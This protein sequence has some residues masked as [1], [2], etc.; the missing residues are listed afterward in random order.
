M[1][2]TPSATSS[3]DG[4]KQRRPNT[5]IEQPPIIEKQPESIEPTTAPEAVSPWHPS[6]FPDGGKDAYLCLLGAACCLFCSFGWINCLGIFQNYYQRNQLRDY[7]PSTIAWIASLEIFCMFLPGPIVGWVYDNHGPRYILIFGTL[8]HVFGLM[9]T[10]LC[11]EFWQFVLAQGICSPLGLNCIFQ[12]GTSSIPTWFLKKRGISY[13]MMAAGSGLGGIIFP[14]MASHLIPKIGYGWTMRTIAFVILGLMCI[15]GLTVKSRLP[16]RPRPFQLKVFLEPF[17]DVSFVLLTTS[18]FLF[19]FGLFIPINF[20]EVQAI[21]NGMSVR[22]AGYLLA[23]LNAASIFGRIIPG[24]LADKVGKFNMQALWCSVAGIIVLALGLPASG[25][26]A[27]ITF[28]AIYGFSSGAFVSLL[29]A[30]IAHIS[31]VEQIGLRV[32]VIFASISFAGLVGNPIAGAIVSRNNGKYW[33]L[34]VFAGIML[35]A[36]ASMFFCTRMYIAKW[37]LLVRV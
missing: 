8:M 21:A 35:L 29:P 16:P 3:I 33:G 5:D 30:Q 19:F 9:M 12:A 1:S 36:G 28:A 6:Q 15:A 10:S 2:L 18:S 7:S 31:K 34:N 4:E 13:G 14:I 25:N 23:V 32:G 22:L 20:I 27:Y 17:H 37:R 11:T 24:A 26:A